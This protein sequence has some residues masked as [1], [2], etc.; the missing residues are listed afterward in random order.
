ML[1]NF[2][3]CMLSQGMLNV[4][5]A[6]M[7]SRSIPGRCIISLNDTSIHMNVQCTIHVRVQILVEPDFFRFS[8]RTASVEY[9]K[10]RGSHSSFYCICYKRTAV[11][12]WLIIVS[13]PAV[14]LST[15]LPSINQQRIGK[16]EKTTCR[17]IA[18]FCVAANSHKELQ[19]FVHIGLQSGCSRDPY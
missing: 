15:K 10:L 14:Q 13:Q 9:K 6:M 1:N 17:L 16:S 2:L 11:Y 19:K 7:W 4:N 3:Y 12:I 18:G 5:S 8:I